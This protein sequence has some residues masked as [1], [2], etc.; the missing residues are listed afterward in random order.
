M[1]FWNGGGS[2]SAEPRPD[3]P[4]TFP[5]IPG[6]SGHLSGHLSGQD[7][8]QLP[9]TTGHY[10]TQTGQDRTQTGQDDV[11]PCPVADRTLRTHR[12]C[13][14]TPLYD[15]WQRP[16]WDRQ[17]LQS[18]PEPW[19][20]VGLDGDGNELVLSL[21]VE[22]QVAITQFMCVCTRAPTVTPRLQFLRF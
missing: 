4:D 21:C 8:T 15:P 12:T 10:R 16:G 20:Q 9:D 19:Q 1:R 22:L 14:D 17:R 3:T 11:R 13:P 18:P 5:D 6:H 2:E 7:R